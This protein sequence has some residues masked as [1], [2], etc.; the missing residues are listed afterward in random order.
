MLYRPTGSVVRGIWSMVM[1]QGE[2]FLAVQTSRQEGV[3]GFLATRGQP[4]SSV[5]TKSI[6]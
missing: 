4:L 6:Y 1:L 2:Q 5:N 3:G